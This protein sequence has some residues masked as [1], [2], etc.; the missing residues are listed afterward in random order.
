MDLQVMAS[1][2]TS[3]CYSGSWSEGFSHDHGVKADYIVHFQAM[4]C[5][6]WHNTS[7]VMGA[8]LS[9][10][11]YPGYGVRTDITMDVCVTIANSH[12]ASTAHEMDEA[13]PLLTPSLH[14]MQSFL[15]LG[16]GAETLSILQY[17]LFKWINCPYALKC[18]LILLVV[19]L[20]VILSKEPH[21]K[22]CNGMRHLRDEDRGAKIW[23]DMC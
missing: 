21:K 14:Q 20:T 13:P 10:N 7:Q 3:Q 19:L 1:R 15:L 11:V 18:L 4:E 6:Q 22:T 9:H 17:Y 16:E 5:N 2:V 12:T 23:R 8:G